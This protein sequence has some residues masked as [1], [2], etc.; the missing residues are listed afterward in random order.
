MR[1]TELFQPDN[2]AIRDELTCVVLAG[3]PGSGKSTAL[4][5]EAIDAPG[6][7]IIA[8]PRI[9]LV[10]E[11]HARLRA[12]IDDMD[13]GSRPTILMIH[14]QQAVRESVDRRLREALY[15]PVSTHLIIV[16]THTAL[17]GLGEGDLVGCHVRIDE[18]PETAIVADEIGLGASW[19]M[20][21]ALYDLIPSREPGWFRLSLR[22]DAK[23]IGLRQILGDVGCSLVEVHRIAASRG[24][25]VEVDLA[26]WED[27]SVSDRRVRWRSIW[28]LGSLRG[29]RS[30]KL[31]AAGY[32][33]SLV[34]YATRRAGGVRVETLQAGAPR[35]GQPQIRI[36]FYTRHAGST[37]W[38]A[39]DGRTCLAAI[40]KHLEKAGFEGYWSS[41]SST[42]PYFVGRLDGPECSPRLSGTNSL[43]HHES[44]AIIYSAK[45]TRADAAIIEALGLDRDVVRAAREDEDLLQF[46]TR[47]AI[48]DP[49]YAG[50]YDVHVYDCEQA[51]R[52]RN[53][54]IANGYDDVTIE[55]V[56]EPGLMAVVRQRHG[57]EADA[58]IVDP[59]TAADRR[60]RDRARE[61]E[62]G[63]RRRDEEKNAR[64]AAGTYRPRGRPRRSNAV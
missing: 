64:I 42:R 11:H 7:Y 27:A 15:E 37:V 56:D 49:A 29:C 59:G 47:G 17:M 23:S 45:A 44:C 57:S 20:M 30:L 25:I 36:H 6:I 28:P 39:G 24:R 46:V 38:W 40:S 9:D 18:L 41:N 43:R 32:S 2:R 3:P 53:I 1:R 19:P 8:A 52:L 14:S 4:I 13:T 12:L 16:T 34:D 58:G 26:N 22:A 50:G 54:L 60:Q 62:R 48:R 33:G 55:T 61:A 31:A 21:A 35:T 63:R 51:G 5:L 10:E